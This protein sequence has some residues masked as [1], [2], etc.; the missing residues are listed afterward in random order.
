[1]SNDLWLRTIMHVLD[2][3]LDHVSLHD[4]LTTLGSTMKIIEGPKVC[5]CYSVTF[6]NQTLIFDWCVVRRGSKYKHHK[7]N[8][9][10]RF[11]YAFKFYRLLHTQ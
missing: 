9:Q 3:R 10:K 6:L 5:G 8:V 7:D 2:W 11:D 4:I 1:M